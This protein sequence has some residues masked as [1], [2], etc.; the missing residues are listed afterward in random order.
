MHELLLHAKT[1]D[2]IHIITRGLEVAEALRTKKATCCGC[3]AAETPPRSLG[4]FRL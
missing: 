3:C 1:L 4:A 2:I